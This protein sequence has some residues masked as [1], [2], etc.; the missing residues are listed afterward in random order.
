MGKLLVQIDADE[1][2]P[3]LWRKASERRRA[4]LRR[5]T[6]HTLTR[7]PQ[8]FTFHSSHTHIHTLELERGGGSR[9]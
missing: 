6:V 9:K 5:V 2:R 1:R 3:A 4:L 7:T 8:Q